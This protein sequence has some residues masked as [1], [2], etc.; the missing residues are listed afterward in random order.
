[1]I[2]LPPA[3]PALPYHP[4]AIFHRV[5]GGQFFKHELDHGI[6]MFRTSHQL[7]ISIKTKPGSSELLTRTSVSP[8]P[9]PCLFSERF[10]CD[11]PR[12]TCFTRAHL[13]AAL[14]CTTQSPTARTSRF[15]P[16]FLACSSPT[17]LLTCSLFLQVFA[18][19]SPLHCSTKST[20]RR[21][22]FSIHTKGAFYQEIF[23]FSFLWGQKADS[24]EKT[25]G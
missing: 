11:F 23:L 13:F 14:A 25:F 7:P 8:H 16:F 3:L 6:P 19:R 1:M 21:L 10:Y 5:A 22:D 9:H 20:V 4:P 18:Q 17:Y 2:S 15:C 24:E 12:P